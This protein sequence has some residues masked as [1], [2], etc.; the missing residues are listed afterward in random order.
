MLKI[1]LD[2]NLLMTPGKF[3]VDIFSEFDRIIN[4]KYKLYTLSGVLKELKTLANGKGKEARASEI[5]LQLVKDKKIEIISSEKKVDEKLIE[6][7]KKEN[8]LIATNDKELIKKLKKKKIGIV[9]LRQKK[10]LIQDK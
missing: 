8:V 4:E 7:G 3:G 9:R 1:I 2:T 10:K 5:A 6:I